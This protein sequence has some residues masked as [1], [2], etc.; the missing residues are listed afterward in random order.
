MEIKR[1]YKVCTF[2]MT[3]N[4]ANYIND[5][6]K[7][8]AMQ[9]FSFPAVFCIIDDASTDGEPDLIR[10]WA[11]DNLAIDD[12]VARK[13]RLSYGELIVANL[14]KQNNS[15][16]VILLLYEN[17]YKEKRNKLTYISEWYEKAEYSAI[18]EGDDYWI[19]AD[20]LHKQVQLL[21]EKPDCMMVCCRTKRYS[22][23]RNI[24]IE[25]NV[26]YPHSQFMD[27]KDVILKGGLFISTC[28][29]VYRRDLRKNYPEYCKK[30]HV[31]DYPLSIMA[32]M[33]GCV[34]YFDEPMAVYRVENPN[35]WV[36]RQPESRLSDTHLKGVLSEVRMLQGFQQDY[37]YYSNTFQ[38]RINS[39]VLQ[40][41]PNRI[42]DPIGYQKY[43]QALHGEIKC[44]SIKY[45][46]LLALKISRLTRLYNFYYL[47][48]KKFEK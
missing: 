46:I 22:Q 12:I 26:C 30:C 27:P 7:G 35:S 6:L 8:F 21:E 43:N 9:S 32:S 11:K 38:E 20:K 23:T 24:F 45:K 3:F 29:I 18:C 14:K 44:L 37:P 40:H 48:K 34:Y 33:K 1:E 25:D 36:G 28:S 31:G 16:F 13:E 17:H 5:V 39:Y 2:C 19:D 15:L 47:L 4:H 41:A 42:K 10:Q